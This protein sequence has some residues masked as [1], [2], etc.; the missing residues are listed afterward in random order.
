VTGRTPSGF[1]VRAER[2]CAVEKLASIM[3]GWAGSAWTTPQTGE[4]RREV[5]LR[6]DGTRSG[7]AVAPAW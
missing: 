6:V 5:Q 3:A 2:G 1:A 4:R 7:G